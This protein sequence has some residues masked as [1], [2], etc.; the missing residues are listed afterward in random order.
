MDQHELDLFRSS[1]RHTFD[2]TKAADLRERLAEEGW[3]EVRAEEPEAA[4]GILFE[5]QGRAL[6]ASAMLDEVVLG[7][8]LDDAVAAEAAG[9]IVVYPSPSAGDR[10]GSAAD[11]SGGVV[12]L[13]GV[14]LC[15]PGAGD[16]LVAPVVHGGGVALFVAQATPSRPLGGL[17][18]DAGW[19]AIDAQMALADGRLVELRPGAWESA[20]AAARRAL[21]HEVVGVAQQMLDMA[22]EHVSGRIQFGR[23]LGAFQAVQMRLADVHIALCGARAA[24]S[25]A[26]SESDVL[27]ATMAKSLASAAHETAARECQ[28]VM[29]GIGFTWE[30]P[31]HRYVRRGFL[32]DALLGS[33]R[34]LERMIGERLVAAGRVPRVP[35]SIE[36]GN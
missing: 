13:S 11:T 5:E 35:A 19:H 12:T 36:T 17:D 4:V 28:Q 8:L 25:A 26:W 15:A 33:V 16:I 1:I 9:R 34:L 14:T 7:E 2:T 20:V 31:F 27:V 18:P 10:P 3:F 24:I 32:C 30:H 21:A 22:V 23:P 6:A 29:G